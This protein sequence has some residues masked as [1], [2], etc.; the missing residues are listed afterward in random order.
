MQL[1]YVPKCPDNVHDCVALFYTYN[2]LKLIGN[3]L[4]EDSAMLCSTLF[5]HST[6]STLKSKDPLKELE[7]NI[8]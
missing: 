3:P 8:H 1:M 2:G 4:A 7:T 6:K 5:L